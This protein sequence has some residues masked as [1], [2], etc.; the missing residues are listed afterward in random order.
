MHLLADTEDERRDLLRKWRS[1]SAHLT[2][3]RWA[4]GGRV[5]V[6][7]AKCL[8]EQGRS[9]DKMLADDPD[10][11]LVVRTCAQVGFWI[12]GI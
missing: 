2:M 10:H 12:G 7:A 5:R 9:M 11:P 8:A 4:A 1:E 6:L 3:D